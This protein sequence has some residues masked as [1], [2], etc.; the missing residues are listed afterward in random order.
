MFV[1]PPSR[2][3]RSRANNFA[4]LVAAARLAQKSKTNLTERGNNNSKEK[5]KRRKK[6]LFGEGTGA[7]ARMRI[8]IYYGKS[9][10]RIKTWGSGG[11]CARG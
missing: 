1:R 3:T 11:S 9:T 7:V 6:T 8:R 2:S 4:C 10:V 5:E